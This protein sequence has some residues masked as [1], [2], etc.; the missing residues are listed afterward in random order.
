M[1]RT[2]VFVLTFI[3]AAALAV[4]ALAIT[5][6]ETP[7]STAT[8][9][10]PYSGNFGLITAP[11][12]NALGVLSLTSI[13]ADKTYIKGEVVYWRISL[14]TPA[15]ANITV[16][17]ADYSDPKIVLSANTAVFNESI[18]SYT[19]SNTSI[20]ASA[21]KGT[22][23]DDSSRLSFGIVKPADAVSNYVITGSAVVT[24]AEKGDISME[25]LGDGTSPKFATFEKITPSAINGKVIYDGL[26]VKYGLYADD[27]YFVVDIAR[28]ASSD[29]QVRFVTNSD[30][31]NNVAS[32]QVKK[33][34]DADWMTYALSLPASSGGTPIETF[35][36]TGGTV[37]T[38]T[39]SDYSQRETFAGAKAA[40]DEVM[41]FFGFN[42]SANG[43]LKA[44]HF[45]MK[46]STYYD[47][48]K[49][50][51][52]A[53]STTITVPGQ[54]VTPPQTGDSATT[55][56]FAMIAL[57]LVAAAAVAYR[58]LKA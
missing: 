43:L 18:M 9:V 52:N 7:D 51:L 22:L 36:L 42:Y 20:T 21:A 27:T 14:T 2:L 54:T 1:K 24:K 48:A 56:G 12:G 25:I 57:A 5:G 3:M 41:K 11:A 40:F 47:S 37:I 45:A 32:I 34:S 16:N 19:V 29:Y 15:Q 28:G 58:K 4:P 31:K 17:A 13:A 10:A 55:L 38:A 44:G 39:S 33:D 50:T 23:N 6:Y 46:L 53:G 35:V 26:N 30:S 49:A 8:A